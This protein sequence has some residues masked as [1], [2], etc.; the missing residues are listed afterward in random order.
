MLQRWHLPSLL[1]FF[2]SLNSFNLF[3]NFQLPGSSGG[4]LTLGQASRKRKAADQVSP[5]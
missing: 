1:I 3:L 5:L 4:G 2:H